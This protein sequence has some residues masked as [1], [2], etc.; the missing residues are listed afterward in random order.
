MKTI[1]NNQRTVNIL[2][3]ALELGFEFNINESIEQAQLEAENFIMSN[4]EGE[5]VECE[6][7]SSSRHGQRVDFNDG[8]GLEYWCQGEI[9]DFSK[10]WHKSTDTKVFHTDLID[11][12]GN[13]LKLY[14]L[15][16]QTD[17]NNF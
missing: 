10:H 9:V 17:Y 4:S 11:S 15:V 16:G 8:M 7:K 5:E 14:Y 6:V 12:L 3:K 1:S 13:Y 2:N